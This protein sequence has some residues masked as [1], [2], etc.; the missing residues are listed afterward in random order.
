MPAAPFGVTVWTNSLIDEVLKADT[1]EDGSF[2]KLQLISDHAVNNTYF[3]GPEQ[4]SRWIDMNSH[5]DIEPKEWKKVET[6]VGQFASGMT[7]LLGNLVQGW[8]GLTPLESEE[9][10]RRF[11]MVTGGAPMRSRTAR[12]RFEGYNY[13]SDTDDEDEH[14]QDSGDTSDSDDD[15]PNNPGGG[16]REGKKDGDN[17]DGEMG[18]G[19]AHEGQGTGD[20]G[21][22]NNDSS[23]HNDNNEAT[24]ND[25]PGDESGGVG[26]GGE[27]DAS[28]KGIANAA[29]R[30]IAKHVVGELNL[31]R[32]RSEMLSDGDVVKCKKPMYVF[33]DGIYMSFKGFCP[34]LK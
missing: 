28:D 17:E 2:G 6:L 14:A 30:E 29:H 5:P 26:C 33:L 8:T 32:Q 15:P 11:A 19:D 16:E 34:F 25:E 9:M 24:P 1:K 13:P 27:S 22:N 21:G 23:G 4:F 20:D 10:S 12:G 18:K 3:G 31:K 7:C